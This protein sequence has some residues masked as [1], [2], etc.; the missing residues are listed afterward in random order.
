MSFDYITLKQW[1]KSW[2]NAVSDELKAIAPETISSLLNALRQVG[3][4]KEPPDPREIWWCP[5]CGVAMKENTGVTF[6]RE[7]CR[8]YPRPARLI[9]MREVLDES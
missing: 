5:E 3:A 7:Q 2:I 4:L 1:P 6:H 9:L 8:G